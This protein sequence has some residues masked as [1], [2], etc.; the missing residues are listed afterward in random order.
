MRY[1]L[2]DYILTINIDDATL[3]RDSGLSKIVIGGEGTYLGSISIGGLQNQWRTQGSPTG[4]YTHSKSLDRTGTVSVNLNQL[5][6]K[7][8][9]FKTIVNW[10]Y[11]GDYEGFTITL[12][13]LDGS[14]IAT[15]Y[16][17]MVQGIPNQDFGENAGEQTW[18]LTCGK[19][20]F[21]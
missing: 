16:D 7:I 20:I 17:C 8:D 5:S 15:C 2:A 13:G 3:A 1:S 12:E 6:S 21:E 9:Q 10:H 18:T 14:K 19:I 4:D 11:K